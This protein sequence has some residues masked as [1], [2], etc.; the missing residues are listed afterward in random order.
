M[1]SSFAASSLS[2]PASKSTSPLLVWIIS[3]ENNLVGVWR[4][5]TTPSLM[6][7]QEGGHHSFLFEDVLG[8][9]GLQPAIKQLR[10]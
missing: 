2:L 4:R 1:S 8:G 5:G 9:W 7:K 3:Q 10:S 6:G